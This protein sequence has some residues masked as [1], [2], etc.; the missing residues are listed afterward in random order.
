MILR[1]E[2]QLVIPTKANQK[3]IEEAQTYLGVPLDDLGSTK[4]FQVLKH[5]SG[6]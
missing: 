5:F 3:R 2:T 1:I 4:V 6:N